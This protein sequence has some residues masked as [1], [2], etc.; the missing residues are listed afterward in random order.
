LLRHELASALPDIGKDDIL[1]LLHAKYAQ[2]QELGGQLLAANL[3]PDELGVHDI[4]RL[5]SHEILSVR[6]AAWAMSERSVERF[7]GAMP[8]AIR[9]LDA[10]WE[11]SR[12]FAF[13]FFR[14]RFGAD[15]LTPPVLV[16]IC[17]GVR[18]E[19]QALGREL[20]TR[21]FKDEY[22]HDYLLRLSEHPSEALQLFASNYLE[23]YAVNDVARLRALT[24]FF[25][26][27]LS[28]VNKARIAKQRCL[29][30]LQTEGLKS[31]AAAEVVAEILT[32]QS[33]TMAIENKALMIEA[34]LRLQNAH[35]GL[36][37]PIQVVG[38]AA[39][40]EQRS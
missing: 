32:R 7:K 34:M 29:R 26:S 35:P 2:A 11:D 6:R 38:V 14:E 22:G 13:K 5:A 36:S 21:Y 19:V 31:R 10:K 40:A 17:D 33:V 24:P 25:V 8:V 30:F 9:L 16:A 15:S 28:R 4:V 18:P 12:A 1:K 3:D 23:R 27:V 20:I 39:R 37:L